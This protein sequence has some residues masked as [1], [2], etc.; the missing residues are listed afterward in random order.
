[1]QRKASDNILVLSNALDRWPYLVAHSL[2]YGPWIWPWIQSIRAFKEVRMHFGETEWFL[3]VWDLPLRS[4]VLSVM[5]SRW[6]VLQLD[7]NNETITR[8]NERTWQLLE[9]RVLCTKQEFAPSGFSELCFSQESCLHCYHERNECEST[10][11]ASLCRSSSK[12]DCTF[13]A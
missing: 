3:S 9:S 2:R 8:N 4:F 7:P 12:S 1:M 13:F 5:Y 6:S 11:L 10:G